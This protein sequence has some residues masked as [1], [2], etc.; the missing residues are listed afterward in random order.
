MMK[1]TKL[2]SALFLCALVAGYS[3]LREPLAQTGQTS[4]PS[5]AALIERG[6]YLVERVAMCIDCHSPRT[7]TGEFDQKRWLQGS[8]LDF[9][10]RHPI[11]NWTDIAPAIAGL[12]GYTEEEA[13]RLLETGLGPNGK[14]L[15][16]PMPPYRLNHEDA[17]A[18]VAY[19]KSL[20][21][22]K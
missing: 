7:P 14:P 6:K 10:P 17:L 21:G 2:L 3:S 18:V 8:V 20:G 11:P 19:L 16:P 22:K 12:P 9:A 4:A 15:R 1:V 5:S 13:V